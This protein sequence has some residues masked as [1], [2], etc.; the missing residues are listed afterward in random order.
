[1]AV[2][3]AHLNRPKLFDTT[4]L[5]AIS[6]LYLE[7]AFETLTDCFMDFHITVCADLPRGY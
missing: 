4:V 5:E 7:N 1:M 6:K 3:Q 2:I